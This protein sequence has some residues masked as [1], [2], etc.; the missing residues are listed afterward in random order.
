MITS[1]DQLDLNKKYT[2]SDYLTWQISER[3]ELIKGKIFKMAPA[4]N[5]KHQDVSR[6]LERAIDQFLMKSKCRMYHA[7]FDVRLIKDGN[8]TVVQPDICVVCDLSKLD[9]QGCK[10]APELIIEILSPGN[11][12]KELREKLNLYEENGVQE[13][14]II[15]PLE[16]M[17]VIYL[18]NEK[19]K[20]VASNPYFAEDVIYSSVLPG[21]SIIIDQIFDI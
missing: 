6:L 3:V 19:G 13:Y 17:L 15:N 12:R 5:R 21:F 7:P 11:S 4:P 2:Y 8:D 16:E 9:K 18:L 10:G 14:W 1:L 20:Y